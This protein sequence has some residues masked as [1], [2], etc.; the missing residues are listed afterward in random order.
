M[1]PP[2]LEKRTGRYNLISV[3]FSDDEYA[4]LLAWIEKHAPGKSKSEVL[5]TK[6]L[7]GIRGKVPA[8][9]EG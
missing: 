5:R 8:S 6:T 7:A 9:G 1:A 4:E 3:A 2:K